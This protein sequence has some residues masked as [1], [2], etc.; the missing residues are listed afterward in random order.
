MNYIYSME[1]RDAR[2]IQSEAQYE[3]RSRCIRMLR[4]GMKQHEV[5]EVL[6]VARGTVGRWWGIYQREGMDG[7]KLR[8]RGRCYGQKRRLDREQERSIQHMLVDKMPDQLKLPFALWTRKAVQEA[9]AQHYGVKLPIRTV[10]DYLHRWGFTPQKPVKR[11]YEQ[12]PER[13]KKWLDEEYPSISLKAHEEGAEILWG[14]ETGI[15]SEDNRG[16]GYAPKGQTPVVYGPGKRFSASMISAINN[17]GKLQFMVY[18][19]ALRVD[20]F[21]KFLRR[22]IK[23]A[24]R[25]IFIIVDNLRVHHAKKV[26]KWVKKHKD[27]IEIFFLPPYSPEHNPDEYMNQDV[28]AHLREKPMPHSDRE[29]KYGLRSYMRRLQWKTDKVARFFDHEMVRYAKA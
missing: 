5:A 21:L 7:L 23:D 17:Q 12:Q 11:A 27:R 6:E 8:R 26:Q 16:R 29:L 14:D 2:K 28:K 3:L 18:E 10:G 15:S 19:G 25:K 20:T 24:K 13:V 4:K 9:I 22:V 1:R